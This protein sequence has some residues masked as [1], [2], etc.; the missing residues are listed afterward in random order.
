MLSTTRRNPPAA[1]AQ[2]I[3][4]RQLVVNTK[5]QYTPP[6]HVKRTT[7]QTDRFTV[8]ARVRPLLPAEANDPDMY[9][10]VTVHNGRTVAVHSGEARLMKQRT[11]H[12]A[13][14]LDHVFG[15][16][17]GTEVVFQ[18]AV[19]GAVASSIPASG[20]DPVDSTVF[21]FGKTGTGKSHT[22]AGITHLFAT[23]IFNLLHKTKDVAQIGLSILELVAGTKGFNVSNDFVTD[24]LND[25]EIVHFRDD[26]HG[27]MHLRGAVELPCPNAETLNHHIRTGQS[28][29]RTQATTRNAGSSRSHLVYLVRIRQKSASSEDPSSNPILSTITLVDLAG[30]ESKTDTL[31]HTDKNQIQD[32]ASINRTLSTLKECIRSAAAGSKVIPFRGSVLTR[33]VKKS[34]VDN[35][36]KT[37][38]IGTLSGIP[39]DAEQSRATV[40]YMGLVKWRLRD[41]MVEQEVE[42]KEEPNVPVRKMTGPAAKHSY[43][44]LKTPV[45]H[46]ERPGKRSTGAE[47]QSLDG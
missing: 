45:L 7:G 5:D 16:E 24:L 12:T 17:E 26:E 46:K 18:K 42:H 31:Y 22:I 27:V 43:L 37:V 14:Y 36:V 21:L 30:T 11:K 9:D 19:R 28:L 15:P 29:R 13:F 2:W 32:S 41:F 35:S 47:S 33:L 3:T 34:F 40:K 25:S 23:D 39:A 38:F 20:V 10:C 4:H 8:C 44:L 6:Q 1:T